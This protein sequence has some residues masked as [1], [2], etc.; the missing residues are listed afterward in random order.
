MAIYQILMVKKELDE[1]ESIFVWDFLGKNE[2][3]CKIKRDNPRSPVQ[4]DL[5]QE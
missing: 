4:R 1:S 2:W 3:I 5:M